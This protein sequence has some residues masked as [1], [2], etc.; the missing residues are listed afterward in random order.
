[1]ACGLDQ[2]DDGRVRRVIESSLETTEK[3]ASTG[4]TW[5]QFIRNIL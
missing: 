5:T 4:H 3:T 2:V 1:M